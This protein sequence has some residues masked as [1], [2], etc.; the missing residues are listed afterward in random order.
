MMS[1]VENIFYSTAALYAVFLFMEWQLRNTY[2]GDIKEIVIQL[3][4]HA[5]LIK[6][7]NCAE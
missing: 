2:K 6:V 1:N 7:A 5:F 3:L 4:A